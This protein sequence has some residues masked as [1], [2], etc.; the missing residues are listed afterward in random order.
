M[1]VGSSEGDGVGIVGWGG[2]GWFPTLFP[3]KL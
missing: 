3:R 2:G 1:W